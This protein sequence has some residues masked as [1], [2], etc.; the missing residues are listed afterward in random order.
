MYGI[1]VISSPI[2]SFVRSFQPVT[3][4]DVDIS[5]LYPNNI[6]QPQSANAAIAVKSNKTGKRLLANVGIESKYRNSD[7]Y[8]V[9][10][11]D[12][13]KLAKKIKSNIHGT[14]GFLIPLKQTSEL[15]GIAHFHRP[16]KRDTSE[17]A[18]HGHHY[19][20]AFF[21]ILHSREGRYRLSRLSN[22]FVF[23][24]MSSPPRDDADIIQFAAGLDLIGSDKDG[25]LLISYGIN[26]C[27]GAAFYLDMQ[28]V[29]QLLLNVSEGQEVVDLMQ[30][31]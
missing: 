24:T 1:I 10:P 29:Q 16:D 2:F 21:T 14:N 7:G 26:D 22:E 19:T 12:R 23:R 28:E 30:K 27:E 13:R 8:D 25:K 17:Y 11:S 3:V 6:L 20:H 15:L 5:K 9:T 4:V 31:I 18:L